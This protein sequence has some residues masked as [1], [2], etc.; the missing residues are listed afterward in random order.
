MTVR[1]FMIASLSLEI[2]STW[3]SLHLREE[4]TGW[5]TAGGASGTAGTG[6]EAAE[7]MEVTAG[8]LGEA[9]VVA[10]TSGLRETGLEE[11]NLEAAVARGR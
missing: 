11:A 2:T 10:V 6:S 5:T 4:W 9:V 1:L 8:A 3:L 7:T